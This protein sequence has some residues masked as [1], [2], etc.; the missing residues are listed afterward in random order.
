V[1]AQTADAYGE[2]ASRALAAHLAAGWPLDQAAVAAGV[3]PETLRAHRGPYPVQ[4][5]RLA[6]DGALLTVTRSAESDALAEPVMLLVDGRRIA[7]PGHVGPFSETITLDEAP[8][9]AQLDPDG[10]LGQSSRVGEVL[11]A[12]IRWT[13]NG[14]ISGINASEGF[15][16][17]FAVLTARRTDDTFN[18]W[19][20][21]LATNQRENLSARLTWTRFFGP[22]LRGNTRRHAVT[23]GVE[24]AW[25]NQRFSPFHNAD[26]AVGGSLSWAW[27]NR[28]YSLFPT[29]GA[30]FAAGISVG[31]APQTGDLYV[32]A[33]ASASRLASP[34]PRHVLAGRVDLGAAWTEIPQE[35]L[36]FG[37][38][39]GVRG[40]PDDVVQSSIQA[41]GSV[42]YRVA[43]LRQASIPLGPVYLSEID[44]IAG[45]DLGVG[46]SGTQPIAAMGAVLGVGVLVDNFGLSPGAVVVSFGFPLWTSGFEI[47]DG[48]PPVAVYLRWGQSF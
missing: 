38:T 19:R 18:R 13:L 27:D 14:Q 40:V 48:T 9:L 47:P 1:L 12:R 34:H 45:L 11:P 28:V 30:A 46:Q 7:V 3:D 26:A 23:L 20:V 33:G 17:A 15:V 32:R 5:Y 37:G 43:P 42:E 21:W 4:D 41:V 44:L 10:H 25:L 24:G 36:S 29:S 8:R 35:R 22:I 6:L 2:A 16:N 39:N 31:G